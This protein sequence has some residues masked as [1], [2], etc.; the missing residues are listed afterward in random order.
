MRSPPRGPCVGKYWQ[1][2]RRVGA[3]CRCTSWG[4][5]VRHA[6]GIAAEGRHLGLSKV[7][8]EWGYSGV[9]TRFQRVCGRQSHALREAGRGT[10]RAA[11]AHCVFSGRF[12]KS[13]RGVAW[14][15]G[16]LGVSAALRLHCVS[17]PWHYNATRLC[18][19]QCG[20]V[21]VSAPLA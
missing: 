14:C 12:A 10:R 17:R 13:R 9:R 4:V 20:R 16:C 7:R 11:C 15:G 19:L 1:R 2:C 18:G 3:I 6:H 8:C 21:C 5:G